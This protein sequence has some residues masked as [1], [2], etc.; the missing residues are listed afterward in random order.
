MKPSAGMAAMV[1]PGASLIL[2]A[3]LATPAMAGDRALIDFIGY[4]ADGGHFAFAESGIQDGSGF[5][6][7]NIYVV[8]VADNAWV[9][10]TPL[11]VRIDDEAATLGAARQKAMADAAPL[12][13][14]LDLAYPVDIWTLAGDGVAGLVE[15]LSFGIPAYGVRTVGEQWQLRLESYEAPAAQP[16]SDYTD[17]PIKGFRLSITGETS[18]TVHADE[19]IPASRGCPLDNSLYA[20]VAPM[21]AQTLDSAVAIVAVY[22]LGFE[23]PDRRFL[24]VPIAP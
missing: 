5:P 3:A 12:F 20:V 1:R 7:A 18:H 23:G 10:G 24:A 15:Q 21:N 14:K 9:S 19:T 13:D 4:S 2:A 16:C 11:R 6:Y 22:P 8:D 17:Q